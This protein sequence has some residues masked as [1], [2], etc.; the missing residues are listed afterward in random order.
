MFYGYVI[1]LVKIQ[2]FTYSVDFY[3]LHVHEVGF[4]QDL[5]CGA[6]SI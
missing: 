4:S 1:F 2:E 3:L 5:R 6:G